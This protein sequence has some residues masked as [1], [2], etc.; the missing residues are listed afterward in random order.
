MGE[1]S[2]SFKQKIVQKYRQ[3][4]FLRSDD[5]HEKQRSVM[6]F[7]NQQHNSRT[8]FRSWTHLIDKRNR[9]HLNS[10]E[11]REGALVS[12]SCQPANLRAVTNTHTTDTGTHS[13]KAFGAAIHFPPLK[14]L[15]AG[16][17]ARMFLGES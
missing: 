13:H 4:F 9:A 2:L 3:S 15:G 14:R 1:S 16:W 5:Q 8:G 17:T 7:E 6:G 12:S 11:G 10:L